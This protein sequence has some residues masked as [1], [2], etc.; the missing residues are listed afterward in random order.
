[1][2]T[3]TKQT[4]TPRTWRVSERWLPVEVNGIPNAETEIFFE[5]D[6]TTPINAIERKNLIAA[7]P[8]LLQAL[9]A[10]AISLTDDEYYQQFKPL[11][12]TVNEAIAKAE[13][14]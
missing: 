8:E 2:K 14:K 7:A 9:K 12:E 1:M 10:V 5:I 13:G 3:Q 4:H 11:L 6:G